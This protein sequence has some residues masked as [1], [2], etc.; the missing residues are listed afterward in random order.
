[1]VKSFKYTL[2]SA[3]LLLFVGCNQAKYVP[4]GK[5]L[6]KGND[7]KFVDTSVD[8]KEISK[9]HDLVSK[10]EMLD[11]IRPK[12][13]LKVKLFFYNRIDTTKHKEQVNKKIEKYRKKNKKR[14]IRE[15]RINK[16]RIEKA[17]AKNKEEYRHK[18]I[19]EKTVKKGWRDWV[20]E[21]MGEPPV[22]LDTSK[23][24][25]T[26]AQLKIY[27]KK[28]GF[29][30][31]SSTDTVF[32]ND[33]KQKAE[34]VYYV[35]P[36]KP[37]RVN[38]FEFD[39]L[40]ENKDFIKQFNKYLKEGGNSIQAGDLLD[41]ETLDNMRSQYSQYCRD[42][43]A[44]FGF[45][46]NYVSFVVDTT[47]GPR[48]ADVTLF[49]KPKLIQDPNNP[50][51][52]EIEFSHLAYKNKDVTFFLHNPG[53]SSFKDYEKFKRRCDELGLDTITDGKYTLLDTLKLY[54][55]GTFIFNEE[56]FINPS[57]LDKQNFLEINREHADTIKFYKEYYVERTYGALSN[58]GVFTT[59]SPTI[60]VDP[61]APLDRYVVVRY[62][63]YPAE[64]QQYLF[65][66]RATT[67]N[68]NLGISGLVSYTNKNLFGGAQ[69]LK[70]GFTGGLESNQLI[71]GDN[72]DNSTNIIKGLNTFEW[73]PSISLSF[74]KLVPMPKSIERKL[75]KRLYPET[76]FDLRVNYQ[77]RTEFKRSLTEFAYSWDFKEG[78]TNEWKLTLVNINFVKLDK[79]QLFTDKLIEINDPFLTNSYT[80]HFTTMMGVDFHYNNLNSD[81]RL[82]KNKRNRN[83]IYD[84]NISLKESGNILYYTGVA[85]TNLNPETNLREL[86]GV[87]YTQFVKTDIQLVTSQYINKKHRVVMRGMGGVIVAYGNSPSAPYEQSFFGGGSNDI[88]AFEARTM[89]PGSTKVYAD[90]NLTDTQIGDLRL[91]ANL[92]WR[93]KLTSLFEGALFVDAG[94]IWN[95]AREGEATTNPSYFR[96]DR[97]YRE[98]AIGTGLGIRADFDFLIVRADFSFPLHNPYLPAGERWF[99][100]DKTEYKTYFEPGNKGGNDKYVRP[101]RP[102][103]AIGIGYPF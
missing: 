71:V 37:Y 61:E 90:S 89:A 46:K 28:K 48:L 1:M 34:L 17:E 64:K 35:N 5:Y 65:E 30:Y 7:I 49:I 94:N 47:V 16:K 67:T 88:R 77:K 45:N 21:N 99:L 10:S 73:G 13:N 41:E 57:L 92:E 56:P 58:L 38:S 81:K 78:K 40:V 85:K 102:R 51:G 87:P 100:T 50:E 66:P 72:E 3:I 62:D 24:A 68:G 82:K 31:A 54:A 69:R 27:L 80:D 98:I 74:P 59:I 15:Y 70:I 93:F 43:G 33:K 22:F 44:Y 42:E 29:Y 97:F 53:P 26:N 25:K 103:I 86:F 95:L 63:L 83:D 75:S 76:V 2:V 23:I 36:R 9:D 39:T 8:P 101:H 32:Y 55:K 6:L 91:E 11:L 96:W 20:R 4:D 12:P 79:E 19:P 52:G 14:R 84:L 18:V 60:T